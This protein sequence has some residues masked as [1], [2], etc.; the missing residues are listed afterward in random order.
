[1][2]TNLARRAVEWP[3]KSP[4]LDR[5]SLYLTTHCSASTLLFDEKGVYFSY[6]SRGVNPQVPPRVN[7]TGTIAISYY[8]AEAIAERR[9]LS[10]LIRALR[11]SL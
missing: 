1:M 4:I 9:R 11:Y 6:T 3:G 8:T 10:A 2:P 7:A 5:G